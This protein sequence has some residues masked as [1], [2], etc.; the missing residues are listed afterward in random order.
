MND[1]EK[2]MLLPKFRIKIIDNPDLGKFLQIIY[3]DLKNEKD[4][5]NSCFEHPDTIENLALSLECSL[6]ALLK[7][8][9]LQPKE[10]DYAAS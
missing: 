9:H 7:T 8:Y 10:I 2:W 5:V 6:N 4:V 1:F 3:G